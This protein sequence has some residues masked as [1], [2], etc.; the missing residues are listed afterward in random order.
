MLFLG[1]WV[2]QYQNKNLISF[3]VIRETIDLYHE[4]IRTID[5][6]RRY[7]SSIQKGTPQFSKSSVP[8]YPST[9]NSSFYK[10]RD[11]QFNML[12]ELANLSDGNHDLL[13]IAEKKG[14]KMLDLLEVKDRLIKA[15]YLKEI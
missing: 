3:K 9:M 13:T 7:Y 2:F 12:L 6:N 8:L 10:K 11:V 14:F 5:E 15:D 1:N 4:V